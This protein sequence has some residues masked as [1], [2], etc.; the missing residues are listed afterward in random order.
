MGYRIKTKNDFIQSLINQNF[1]WS[2]AIIDSSD[3]SDDLII[4]QVLCYGEPDDI[5]NLK[6]YFKFRQI[7][8]VWQFRLLPDNRFKNSNVWL[9][10]VFFNIHQANKYIA[11]YSKINNR[12]DH[13]RLLATQN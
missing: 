10:R 8:Q 12:D 5:I 1:F 9:A 3:L 2:Y 6:K 4:E 11:K 13:L 7:K